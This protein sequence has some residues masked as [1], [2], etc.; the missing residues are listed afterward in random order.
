MSESEGKARIIAQISVCCLSFV[1]HSLIR[2]CYV[3]CLGK[4]VKRREQ[5][6]VRTYSV[7]SRVSKVP[8]QDSQQ[9]PYWSEH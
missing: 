8:V 3:G 9:R 6:M 1:L 7:P 2:T 5:H 4:D